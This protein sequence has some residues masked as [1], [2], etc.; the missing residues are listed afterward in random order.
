MEL[1][2]AVEKCK[3][4]TQDSLDIWAILSSYE[5]EELRIAINTVLEELNN[6][7]SKD[8]IENKIKE[9]KEKL[10]NVRNKEDRIRNGIAIIVLEYCIDSMN[11][12][13]NKE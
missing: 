10:E 9:L 7:I 13:L 5:C 4:Y 8:K 2:E 1:L 3:K 12:L 11:E 6:S